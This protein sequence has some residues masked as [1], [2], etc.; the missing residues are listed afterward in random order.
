MLNWARRAGGR[1]EMSHQQT[2]GA[3]SGAEKG[4]STRAMKDRE[5]VRA[6]GQWRWYHG[7]AF[8]VSVQALTFGLSGLTSAFRGT[9]GTTL[10][11]AVFGDVSYF[12]GLRQAV[13]APPSWVFGP[14]WTINN[15]CAIWG[16]LRVLRLPAD[17]PG[18][19]A[20]LALQAGTWLDYVVFN[21]AYFSLRS[22]LNA[23]GLTLLFALL[24]VASMLVALLRLKDTWVALSLA[25]TV[26]WLMI[27]STAAVCQALW[28]H[29][30][31][32]DVGPFSAPAPSLLKKAAR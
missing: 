20:Y 26:V 1:A 14:V 25:T 21:A 27:A 19:D 15:V 22:P 12:R 3:A 13:V 31:F 4:Q 10:R 32:Y 5:G 30:D 17:T 23:L 2:G 16:A 28:N 11:E 9:Q 8:Y 29:D 24:T 6:P 7:V 18:R